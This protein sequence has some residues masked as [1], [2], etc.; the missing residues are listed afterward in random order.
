MLG[1]P[2]LY[3]GQFIA[4]PRTVGTGSALTLNGVKGKGNGFRFQKPFQVK[5]SEGKSSSKR[6][7]PE[8]VQAN[9][10]RLEI[11][12]T[13]LDI[14]HCHQ[15]IHQNSWPAMVDPCETLKV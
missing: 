2:Q 4:S 10:R 3:C 12:G 15:V 11:A 7:N 5:N 9:R 6:I 1:W 14:V 8:P 13:G